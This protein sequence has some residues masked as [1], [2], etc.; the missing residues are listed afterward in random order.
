MTSTNLLTRPSKSKYKNV[1]FSENTLI[2]LDV[3]IGEDTKIGSN[4]IIEHHVHIGKKLYYRT[5]CTYKKFN[6]R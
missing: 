4:S 5:R 1:Y 2:G 6:N 3:K